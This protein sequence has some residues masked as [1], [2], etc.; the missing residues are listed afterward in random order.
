MERSFEKNG[1]EQKEWK[2][3]L[4][5]TDAQPCS[6]TRKIK[7]PC[8]R[9]GRDRLGFYAEIQTTVFLTQCSGQTDQIYLHFYVFLA[10]FFILPDL[11]F[12]ILIS[13]RNV[14]IRI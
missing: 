7:I 5:R 3:L 9:S 14:R 6:E 13:Q 1:K 12:R 10:I 4:K 8:N 2:V 11:A